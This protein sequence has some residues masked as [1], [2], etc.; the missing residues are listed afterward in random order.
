MFQFVFQFGK[1]STF[2]KAKRDKS[3]HTILRCKSFRLYVLEQIFDIL[4][5]LHLIHATPRVGSFTISFNAGFDGDD[6]LVYV[7]NV[8]RGF[9]EI[10]KDQTIFPP[11]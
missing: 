9:V 3:F 5:Y 1:G 8:E 7:N 4:K 6:I 11:S 10:L 2:V